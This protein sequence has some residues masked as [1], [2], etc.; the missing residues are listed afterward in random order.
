MPF[1]KMKHFHLQILHFRFQVDRGS[2]KYVAYRLFMPSLYPFNILNQK[3][4]GFYLYYLYYI[5]INKSQSIN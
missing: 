1:K 4:E 2:I 3:L 5:K